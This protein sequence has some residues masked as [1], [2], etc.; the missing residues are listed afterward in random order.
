MTEQEKAKEL[1]D[2]FSERV[3]GYVGSS[4]LTNYEYPSEILRKAKECATRCAKEAMAQ[5]TEGG[6]YYWTNVVLEI[7]AIELTEEQQ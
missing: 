4:F 3:H 6:K 1:V 7:N 5:A 2:F